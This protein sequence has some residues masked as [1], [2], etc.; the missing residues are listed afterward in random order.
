MEDNIIHQMNDAHKN[1]TFMGDDTWMG[2][3]PRSFQPSF[4]FPSFDV[5]DIDTVDEGVTKH[6]NRELQ[7]NGWNLLIAHCLGVDHVGHRFGPH[8]PVMTEKLLQM[9]NLIKLITQKMNK[10]TLL[11]VMGDHGMTNNGDHGGDSS[12]ETSA[13]L[14]V[15]SPMLDLKHNA[16]VPK[17]VNQIDLVPT[18]ALLMGVPI[19]YSNLGMVILDL[20]QP[21]RPTNGNAETNEETQ[22]LTTLAAHAR[23]LFANVNQ[24]WHYLESYHSETPITSKEFHELGDEF[25]KLKNHFISKLDIKKCHEG[26]QSVHL[27]CPRKDELEKFIASSKDFLSGAREMCRSMWARFDLAAITT[28]L[29]V[30]LITIIIHLTHVFDPAISYPSVRT[31]LFITALCFILRLLS[32]SLAI[33]TLALITLYFFK[34][35]T[36][37]CWVPTRFNLSVLLPAVMALSYTS[38]SFVVEEPYV[39]H[40]LVQ[41]LIWGP[42]VRAPW[43]FNELLDRCAL[44]VSSRLGLHYFRCREEQSPYCEANSFHRSLSSLATLNWVVSFRVICA[45]STFLF[46]AFVISTRFRVPKPIIRLLTLIPVYW[47]AQL[48][49]VALGIQD[50]IL[51][52]LPWSFYLYFLYTLASQLIFILRPNLEANTSDVNVNI[53]LLFWALSLLLGGDGLGPGIVSILANIFLFRTLFTK[54]KTVSAQVLYGFLS[55]HGFFATGHHTSLPNIPW[56]MLLQHQH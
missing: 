44:S 6:L 46:I 56:Y 10:E 11:I 19:P 34:H 36:W 55:M 54:E 40:F 31:L 5:W 42:L 35:V 47:I 50:R 14:F 38:N 49:F 13:G 32:D 41:T 18:L 39:S 43:T 24:I 51:K 45:V 8:H 48:A 25:L 1:L 53:L 37:K 27:C 20:I 33:G 17:V 12:D 52:V 21:E 22:H 3:F 29:A 30:F 23:A 7:K 26:C 15:Y 28:G 16:S 2:L 4:P 9:N